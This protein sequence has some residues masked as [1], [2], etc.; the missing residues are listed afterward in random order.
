VPLRQSIHISPFSKE[1]FSFPRLLDASLR[2]C[3]LQGPNL[4][5]ISGQGTGEQREYLPVN[6][7][8][9]CQGDTGLERGAGLVT[10]KRKKCFQ[11]VASPCSDSGVTKGGKPISMI[12]TANSVEEWKRNEADLERHEQGRSMHRNCQENHL[13]RIRGLPKARMS[14]S[15]GWTKVRLSLRGRGRLTNLNVHPQ[16]DPATVWPGRMG[17]THCGCDS[18]V[19]RVGWAIG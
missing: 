18:L 2:L 8:M 15:S 17:A 19:V 13:F 6:I 11:P 4:V 12:L 9:R 10:G 5:T 3:P 16:N 7:V 14:K 1:D